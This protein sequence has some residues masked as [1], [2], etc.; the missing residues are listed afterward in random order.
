MDLVKDKIDRVGGTIEV[1]SK[2][3]KY[4][5]FTIVIPRSNIK[6]DS[7]TEEKILEQAAS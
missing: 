3:G 7:I 1:D 4:C 6:K 2:P 5:V